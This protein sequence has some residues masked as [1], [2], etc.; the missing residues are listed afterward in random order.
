VKI[1]I[2]FCLSCL[3]LPALAQP[4]PPG[5][6]EAEPIVTD[7][8]DFTEAAVV[9][10]RRRFQIE[11]GLT[12][13]W[14]RGYRS[15]GLPETLFRYGLTDRLELRF[16]PP[17]YTF[18]R[19][20]GVSTSAFG[21]TYL[22]AKVQLGPLKDGTDVALI[23]AVFVPA[24]S[25]DFGTRTVD[26]E[27]KLCVSRELNS[28]YTLSGMLYFAYPTEDGKRNPTWQ[29]TLSL[30]HSLTHRLS[31]FVELS[32]VTPQRGAPENLLHPGFAFLLTQDQQVD[33]HFG[34]RLNEAAPHSFVAAGYSLR[35]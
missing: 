16:A 13:T 27:L 12:Q 14:G 35:F 2:A 18:Q 8:P 19:A 21:A 20:G 1:P 28:R 31:M 11:S 10:P 33:L 3:A 29:G 25:R 26:P 7:R 24:G 15:L 17:N 34:F 6:I 32:S 23:P 4:P 5:R 30:G 22:G 9:V